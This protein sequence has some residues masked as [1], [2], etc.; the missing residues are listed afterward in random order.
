MSAE[1]K[2]QNT[3]YAT[4]IPDVGEGRFSIK[5]YKINLMPDYRRDD[6]MAKK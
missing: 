1:S 6:S 3:I 2:E 5:D 4:E